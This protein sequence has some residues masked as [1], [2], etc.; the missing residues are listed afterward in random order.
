MPRISRRKC[1]CTRYCGKALSYRSRLR[2]YR[3]VANAGGL[4]YESSETLTEDV[5][6]EGSDDSVSSTSDHASMNTA[7]SE[8]LSSRHGHASPMDEDVLMR[9]NSPT[10]SN[11]D[12]T[13]PPLS[14]D[15]MSGDSRH[16]GALSAAEDLDTHY[17]DNFED[18]EEPCA[19][20]GEDEDYLRWHEDTEDDRAG[21]E[22]K[23][24]WEQIMLEERSKEAATAHKHTQEM[25]TPADRD[26]I[27]AFRLRFIANIPRTAY[28][29][30][31]EAFS[32]RIKLDSEW[33]LLH[34]I[35]SLSGVRPIWYECC[36]NS[37]LAYLGE[38]AN[39]TT[40]A[41]CEQ[42]RYTPAGRP[43]RY[44]C[45]IPLIPRLQVL[46]ESPDLVKLMHYRAQFDD[47]DGE[48]IR[49]VFSSDH[50][51]H[52]RGS[53]VVVD[54]TELDYYHFAD[55]RDIAFALC[56]DAYLFIS[57]ALA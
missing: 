41:S 47:D 10:M 32:S 39:A 35:A 54:N 23:N 46:F 14:S 49:D 45:Y 12:S 27:I 21:L 17:T 55:P 9:T 51:R 38:Y 33:K 42:P 6:L 3:K 19:V 28:H 48:N 36:I 44:F 53:R 15:H 22:T 13:S 8:P 25:L 7:T 56:T 43:R 1:H 29:Q 40:C 34:R 2:H 31:R 24:I 11:Q 50:Y 52:L 26:N 37:C 20:M 30:F 4:C 18:W 57:S 5:D 16:T